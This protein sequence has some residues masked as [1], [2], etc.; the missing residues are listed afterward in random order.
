[1]SGESL[2][3]LNADKNFLDNNNPL[4]AEIY[5]YWKERCGDRP[6]PRRVDIDPVELTAHLPGILL[7]DVDRD[8]ETGG[9]V[10]RYRVVGTREVTNRHHNPTG[11]RVEEGYFAESA[12][13]ALQSYEEL[14][15][16]RAPIFEVISFLSKDGVPVK[17]DSI[18]LPLS[19]NSTDV[20]QIL[21]Y[22]EKHR[23]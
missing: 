18:M 19:E 8:A 20:S 9:R 3:L 5:T 4:I 21:V 11:K 13:A 2:A 10:F 23:D 14:C 12:D 17:E 7:I 15:K 6:M 22:S 16:R 1:M